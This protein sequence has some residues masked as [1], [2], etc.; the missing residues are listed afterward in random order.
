[1]IVPFTLK[2]VPLQKGIS[3]TDRVNDTMLALKR[4]CFRRQTFA[5]NVN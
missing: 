5:I 2:G 3:G 4:H 1:M